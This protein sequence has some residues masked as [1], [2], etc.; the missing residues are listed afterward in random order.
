MD[1]I[2]SLVANSG[3]SKAQPSTTISVIERKSKKNFLI[4]DTSYNCILHLGDKCIICLEDFKD[5]VM[6]RC[7][8]TVCRGCLDQAMAAS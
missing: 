3:H 6:T 2:T 7:K 5:P 1:Y 8:H 4:C